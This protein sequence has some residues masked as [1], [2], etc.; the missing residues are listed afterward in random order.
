MDQDTGRPE[1]P[2]QGSAWVNI[3]KVLLLVV[4]LV[5]AWFLL[6]RLIGGK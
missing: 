1:G 4:V 6:E 3:G 2:E 5:A